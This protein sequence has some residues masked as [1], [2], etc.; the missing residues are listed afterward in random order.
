MG[1]LGAIFDRPR[2]LEI[3][4]KATATT[5]RVLIIIDMT[6]NISHQ[7]EATP[8]DNAIENGSIVSD[9]V[10]VSP[11]SVSFEGVISDNPISLTQ[12][13]VGNVAGAV[14]AIGGF[15]G[16]AAGTLFTGAVATLGGALLNSPGN[17]VQEAF[18]SLR[19]LQDK[20]IPVTL[21]TGLT[22]YNNMILQSFNPTEEARDGGSLV[23]TATFRELRIVKSEQIILSES[24]LAEFVQNKASSTQNKGKIPTIESTRGESI[25][26]RLTGIG[27]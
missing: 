6:R 10:D 8:T 24:R 11:K 14:P 17:R 18:N 13:I 15:A 19:E 1:I 9:H 27:Q 16:E 22:S 21:I 26:S 12:A 25:L 23:F 2:K 20:A 4:A 3:N 7:N 5:E